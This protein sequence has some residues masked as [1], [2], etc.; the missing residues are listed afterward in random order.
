M[1]RRIVREIGT[2]LCTGALV[3]VPLAGAAALPVSSAVGTLALPEPV[4]AAQGDWLIGPVPS[5]AAHLGA[6]LSS[7]VV[8]DVVI[9]LAGIAIGV[10]L[11]RTSGPIRA[12]RERSIRDPL[13]R[14]YN[15]HHLD[16]AL[17]RLLERHDRGDLREVS[18]VIVD[19]DRFKAINDT[20]GHAVGDAVIRR[21]GQ[22]MVAS[23]R[24]DDLVCRLG[25]EEFVAVL[26]GADDAAAARYAERVR[27]AVE[28][29]DDLPPVPSGRFTISA[30]VARRR[31]GEG[32]DALLARA[33]RGLYAAKDGGRN[34]VVLSVLGAARSALGR[35]SEA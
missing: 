22:V 9:L 31:P 26:P 29:T 34:R 5:M 8:L 2:T 21:L 35:E 28:A 17:P 27:R 14:A 6:L 4:L 32:V 10:M 20:W 1:L 33:D 15:R 11:H 19:I 23:A 13:S 24:R 18:L 16:E 25:G 12:I 3:L 30:G 7:R